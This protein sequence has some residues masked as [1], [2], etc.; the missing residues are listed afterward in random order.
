MNND[1]AWQRRLCKYLESCHS[2]EFI[3]GSHAEVSERL[4]E[5]KAKEGYVDP[6]QT[7]PDPPTKKCGLD[8]D[9]EDP[10]AL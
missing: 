7:L 9:L 4:E 1:E 3:M 8:H 2:G 5:E 10:E 6:T